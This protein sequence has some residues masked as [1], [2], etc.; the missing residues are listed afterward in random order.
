MGYRSDIKLVF[1]TSNDSTIPFSA[2][3]F[4]FDENFPKNDFGDVE[5]G[6]NYVLVSYEDV[7]WY[8]SYPEVEAVNQ[9]IEQFCETFDA[10]E[11]SNAHYEMIRVG[12]ELNDIERDASA[13]NH[14]LLDVSRTIHFN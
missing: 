10:N 11:D 9:A 13:Y 3:K 8:S 12:E 7:K 6:Q 1:Y 2:V 14:Y 4:W 5:V